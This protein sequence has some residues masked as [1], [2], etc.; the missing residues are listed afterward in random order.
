[1]EMLMVL[2]AA[3]SIL[4]GGISL[5]ALLGVY[6]QLSRFDSNLALLV[7]L[8]GMVGL[9][10]WAAMLARVFQAAMHHEPGKKRS[11]GAFFDIRSA[12]AA[13]PI[14][15]SQP[16]S[17]MDAGPERE[18]YRG[19]LVV[20]TNRNVWVKSDAYPLN[21]I[22]SLQIENT[23]TSWCIVLR[24]LDNAER[25]LGFSVNETEVCALCKMIQDACQA[26]V[27]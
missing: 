13:P 23:G 22:A 7:I 21:R 3:G 16:A 17:S 4:L 6:S 26:T 12:E 10:A 19:G 11:I 8:Q 20:L 15:I 27:R 24:T 25:K 5:I 9:A 1:M 2:F 14:H 18:L